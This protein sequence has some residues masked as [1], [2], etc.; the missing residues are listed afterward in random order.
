MLSATSLSSKEVAYRVCIACL[1]GLDAPWEPRL[2]SWLKSWK[3]HW[4][5]ALFQAT[6]NTPCNCRGHL[7]CWPFLHGDR[8]CVYIRQLLESEIFF[9]RFHR[10]ISDSFF[11]TSR[12][13]AGRSQLPE[14]GNIAE[15]RRPKDPAWQKNKRTE[16]LKKEQCKAIRILDKQCNY[17]QTSLSIKVSLLFD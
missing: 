9:Y 1:Q 17:Y 5:K 10:F 15:N 2:R 12:Q 7:L 3:V 11:F 16:K 14:R 13:F 6:G 8:R 4:G